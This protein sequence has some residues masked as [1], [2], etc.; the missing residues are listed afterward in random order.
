[1][2]P[3]PSQTVESLLPWPV[4][5]CNAFRPGRPQICTEGSHLR[6]DWDEMVSRNGGTPKWLVYI[7]KSHKSGDKPKKCLVFHR[8]RGPEGNRHEN[9]L[10][11][12]AAL[13]HSKQLASEC[14][15][16]LDPYFSACN[17]LCSWS[18]LYKT[19]FSVMNRMRAGLILNCRCKVPMK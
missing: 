11:D 14:K 7:G 10:Q 9:M 15:T 4:M 1:M 13:L 6:M 12:L 17:M 16:S 2:D 19:T 8:H 5:S 3:V 18:P